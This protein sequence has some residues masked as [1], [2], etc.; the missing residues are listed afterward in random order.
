M[1]IASASPDKV[2]F[3]LLHMQALIGY[4][5]YALLI[6]FMY[7]KPISCGQPKI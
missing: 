7:L 4:L 2:W 6:L 3:P 1:V 5:N